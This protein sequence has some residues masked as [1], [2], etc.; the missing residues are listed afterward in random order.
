MPTKGECEAAAI[1]IYGC[2]QRGEYEDA[3]SFAEMLTEYLD[4]ENGIS[5]D[6]EPDV[7]RWRNW[8][9][10]WIA[11]ATPKSVDP[12]QPT[13]KRRL[14]LKK[15][16]ALIAIS[17][18]AGVGSNYMTSGLDGKIQLDRGEFA[19]VSQCTECKLVR[20]IESTPVCPQC[21]ETDATSHIAAPLTSK[22][23]GGFLG[24]NQEGWQ[25]K[26]GSTQFD[27]EGEY[28]VPELVVH[29]TK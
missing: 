24:N 13:K 4:D 15:A 14:T 20:D 1:N 29:S 12:N 3:N 17:C 16:I 10:K 8:W 21:G 22:W 18:I 2:I 5:D 11:R 26:D 27:S 9:S 28:V 23:L 6:P 7:R 25:F 19:Q